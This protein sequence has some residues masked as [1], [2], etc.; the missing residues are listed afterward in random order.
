MAADYNADSEGTRLNYE[1]IS[2]T[3]S[4]IRA[5]RAISKEWKERIDEDREKRRS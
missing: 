1:V 5:R 3:V 2:Q 4:D